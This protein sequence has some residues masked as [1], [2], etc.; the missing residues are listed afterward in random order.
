MLPQ[1]RIIGRANRRRKIYGQTNC[2]PQFMKSY[3]QSNE[4]VCY[5]FLLVGA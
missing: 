2:S 5:N 3:V 4:G 1:V